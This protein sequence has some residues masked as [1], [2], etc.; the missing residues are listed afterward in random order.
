[1]LKIKLPGEHNRQNATLAIEALKLL[2]LNGDLVAAIETFPGTNRRFEKLAENLY[3]DYGHHP[4]EI[5]A[6]LQMAR[7]ISDNVVLVYQPHQNIRQHQIIDDYK[8]QFLKAEV[9]YWL[10]TYL[11]RENNNLE[12]LKPEDLIKN[13]TNKDSIVV[14]DFDDKLWENIE[15]ERAAGKLVICMGAGSIDGWVRGKIN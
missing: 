7:E 2:D 12:I 8:D 5:E 14:S 9:I 15:R 10:P 13:I 11:S 3:S 1:V 4:I 6:T